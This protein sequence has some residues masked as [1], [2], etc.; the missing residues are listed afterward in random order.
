MRSRYPAINRNSI[1]SAGQ[2]ILAGVSPKSKPQLMLK[3][4]GRRR[5]YV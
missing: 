2:K 4:N 5:R 3:G 1:T